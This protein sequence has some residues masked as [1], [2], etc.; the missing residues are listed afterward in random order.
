MD[1]VEAKA[2]DAPRA[3]AI[4]LRTCR[5]LLSYA[6]DREIIPANPAADLKPGNIKTP[7]NPRGLRKV[8]RER[9]LSDAEVK[10]FWQGIESSGMDRLTALALKFILTTGAR[11]GEVAGAEWVEIEGRRWIVPAQRRGKTSKAYTVHLTD[12]ALA[13]LK[14]AQAEVARRQKRRG[15]GEVQFVFESRKGKPITRH[16]LSRA[17]ARLEPKPDWTPHD[18]RRT[19]RTGLSAAGVRPD[20]AELAIGHERQGIIGVYDKFA[21][22]SECADALQRWEVRLIAATADNVIAIRPATRP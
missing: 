15:G 4:L 6:V 12:T 16:A 19:M 7:E 5:Q 21:F 1:V 22:E 20:I 9:V 13:I 18:L 2:T 17:V 10:A 8:V 3:A 14:D 11:P